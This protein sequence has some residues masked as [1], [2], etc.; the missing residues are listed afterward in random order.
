MAAVALLRWN[1]H[2]NSVATCLF[3]RKGTASNA[4]LKSVQAFLALSAWRGSWHSLVPSYTA[5]AAL[6]RSEKRLP[7]FHAVLSAGCRTG[8]SG[9]SKCFPCRFSLQ[10]QS[11]LRDSD[12]ASSG[13]CALRGRGWGRGS[14]CRFWR[15]SCRTILISFLLKS[16]SFPRRAF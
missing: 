12:A 1:S 3:R 11:P 15:D 7:R 16:L 8:S 10:L 4:K 9:L 2:T 14:N 13:L 6:S 5:S